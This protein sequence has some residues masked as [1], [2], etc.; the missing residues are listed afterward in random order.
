M[1]DPGYAIYGR[2]MVVGSPARMATFDEARE[3]PCSISVKDYICRPF[4]AGV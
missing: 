3:Q 4:G 1:H 2:L